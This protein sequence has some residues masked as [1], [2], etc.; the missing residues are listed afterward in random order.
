MDLKSVNALAALL[1]ARA[2]CLRSVPRLSFDWFTR[3]V[4]MFMA[5]GYGCGAAADGSQPADGAGS[6]LDRMPGASMVN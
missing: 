3:V 6:L 2:P 5:N 1:P 4:Y